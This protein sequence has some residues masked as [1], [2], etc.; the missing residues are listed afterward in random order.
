MNL[1]PFKVLGIQQ[2][3]IG[4]PDKMKLRQL[5]VDMLGLEITG[6]FVSERENVDEDITAMG[7]GPFKVEVDLMQPIDPEKTG[8]CTPPRSITWDCGS[9]IC[10]RPSNG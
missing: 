9:T 7:K 2:I 4:G 1:R 6:N 3:A 5:W 8:K 10:P